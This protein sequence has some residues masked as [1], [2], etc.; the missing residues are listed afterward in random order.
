MSEPQR[1]DGGTRRL[2]VIEKAD[3]TADATA[4]GR[5][6]DREPDQSASAAAYDPLPVLDGENGREKRFWSA[7]RAPAG[8]LAVLLL[9][10]AG[11]FLYDVAA[12]RADRPAM[13]WRRSLARELAERPLD[14]TWVLVGAAVAVLLGLWLFV[15]AVT[16][17]LRD[18]LPMRRVHPDVRAGLHRGAAALAL[19]DRAMEVS[20]V[21][22]V[23]VRAGR[24]RVDVRAVSHF[25]EL[26][27]V[28]ADLDV[29]LADGI[30]GLGLARP[31]ALS[32]HVRRP[33]RKG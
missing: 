8:I 4:D 11:L 9:A 10:G 28:R 12:V 29:T 17:G 30:R 14:D 16:P 26:D 32:V 18:V 6:D 3:D 13:Q 24:R 25:R 19:R 20:G 23:R 7:R 22:S 1:S 15:L 33:G 31:P 2:P 21:R 27:E 5:A